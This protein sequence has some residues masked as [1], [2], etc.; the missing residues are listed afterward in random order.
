MG[1]YR[2]RV[3]AAAAKMESPGWASPALA[4]DAFRFL[5]MPQ[6]TITPM[7]DGKRVELQHAGLGALGR[8][9]PAGLVGTVEFTLELVGKGTAYAAA[10]TG[11][12]EFEH[13]C[14]LR[15][16]LFARSFAAGKVIYLSTDT[17]TQETFSLLLHMVDG[18]M[19]ELTGCV[20]KPKFSLAL[21]K[22]ATV[23]YAV[24]GIVRTLPAEASI[25]GLVL[26]STTPP[27]WGALT[28][29]IGSWS[30]A[31]TA[32][33]AL[34]PKKLDLDLQTVTTNRGWAGTTPLGFAVTD[35]NARAMMEVEAVALATF[36]PYARGAAAVAGMANTAIATDVGATAGNTFGIRTGQ[37]A[38]EF[39][40]DVDLG[41]LAGWGLEG[42]LVARSGSGDVAGR[43][44]ALTLQ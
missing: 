30:T 22:V 42:D 35:R 31:T 12:A 41:G 3:I 44:F 26:P 18:K 11:T 27:V 21:N 19:V 14:F 15:S 8:A 34:A 36:D 5:G 2:R 6:L 29:S 43:E 16:A 9:A 39:P 25:T 28:T 1:I 37:W 23:T 40:K 10:P 7:E 13:D 17:G 24:E 4:T 20:A 33:N 32:P 38:L